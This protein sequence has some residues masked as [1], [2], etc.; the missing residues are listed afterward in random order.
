MSRNNDVHMGNL[1]SKIIF[2]VFLLNKISIKIDVLIT[3]FDES[4]RV[5][6][7]K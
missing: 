5:I 2:T 6:E 3:L 7:D 1:K 4:L